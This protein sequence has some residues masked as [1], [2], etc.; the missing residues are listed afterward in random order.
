[1]SGTGRRVGAALALVLAAALV[2]LLLWP[3][4]EAV[5]QLVLRVYLFFLNEVGVPPS[6]G[7][8]AYAAALNVVVF[9]VV[10]GVG[11]GVLHRRPLLV[12]LVLAALSVFSEVAQA[13]PW[14]GRDPSIVDVA[15]NVVG[16][17]VGALLA[18]VVTRGHPDDDARVDETGDEGLHPRPDRLG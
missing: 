6:V 17:S 13:T 14:L 4:G 18:S 15:C 1:M 12:V 3:D 16:A 7:P 9:A 8:E 2:V 11:V 5:R 10:A